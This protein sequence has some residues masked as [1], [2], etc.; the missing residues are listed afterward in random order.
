LRSAPP[1][2]SGGNVTFADAVTTS[3]QFGFG[4]GGTVDTG[5]FALNA[6][7]FVITGVG[8][9]TLTLGSSNV[10]LT[11]AAGW[12]YTGSNLTISP[13][14][15]TI[16]VSGTGAFAGGGLT[17]HNVNLTGT[18]HTISGNNTFNT[19]SL[20]S[21]TTQTITFT[22]NSYQNATAL[23]LGGSS[24]N[25]H[26]LQGSGTAGWGIGQTAGAVSAN[27]ITISRSTGNVSG[28]T[29]YTATGGSVDGG[30]NVNWS[31][32]LTIT[33][34][35]TSGISMTQDGVT[36]GNLTG[37]ITDMGGQASVSSWAQYGLTT[38]YGS[39]TANI[40]YSTTNF[41]GTNYHVLPAN[42][43]PGATYHYRKAITSGANTTYGADQSFTYTMPTPVAGTA[44]V[45]GGSQITFN[46]DVTSAGVASSYYRFIDYWPEGQAHSTTSEVSD[47]GTGVFSVAVDPIDTV[48]NMNYRVG[49]RVGSVETYSST[50]TLG[51]SYTGTNTILYITPTIIWIGLLMGF[52]Y[53]FFKGYRSMQAGE[54][55]AAALLW[56][57]AF[58]VIAVDIVLWQVAW[59]ALQNILGG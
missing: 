7:S 32:P 21:G 5:G 12:S 37:T 51:T 58:I 57:I 46:G 54:T 8:I 55:Q 24:G 44:T 19:F 35:A 33:S 22:D 29:T 53:L 45:T 17:Y 48:P 41:T 30:N 27:Y 34:G 49:I 43:T 36:S 2:L 42:L 15:A 38:A 20:S 10:T 1:V 25:Q 9:K 40:T 16:N 3:N 4:A 50:A 14:T 52:M 18:A 26:T 11:G 56:S 23:T 47:S 13:N 31:F 6:T 28:G 39:N 59:D